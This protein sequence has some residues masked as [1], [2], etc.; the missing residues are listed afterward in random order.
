MRWELM[1][2]RRHARGNS[3][4][5]I[6]CRFAKGP[7]CVARLRRTRVLVVVFAAL[8]LAGCADDTRFDPA[9]FR[10]AAAR[11]DDGELARQA[12]AAE[13]EQALVGARRSEVHKLLGKPEERWLET[14]EEAWDAGWVNNTFG[15]GDARLLVIGY[16]HRWRVARVR[17]IR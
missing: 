17:V 9:K 7:A 4:A 1:P 11:A 12:Y 15:L 14:R 16:D 3:S 2:V 10:D 8:A 6:R 5:E 13:R